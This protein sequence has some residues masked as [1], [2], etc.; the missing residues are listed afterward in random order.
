MSVKTKRRT[1]GPGGGTRLALRRW[2]F[3]DDFGMS[4]GVS[5]T[6]SDIHR[7]AT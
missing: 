3:G 1:Q 5:Q 4:L 2:H 7:S 6:S